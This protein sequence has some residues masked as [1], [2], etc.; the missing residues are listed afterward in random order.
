MATSKKTVKSS[1]VKQFRFARVFTLVG[2]ILCLSSLV[3]LA[4]TFYPVILEEL[5]YQYRTVA[6]TI[7]KP[8]DATPIDS[9]FGIVIPRL[10]A[11]ARIIA[12]VDPFDA[13][14]YQI[15]L[16]RGVA[17]ARGTSYPGNP[18]NIFLFSH[19]SVDFYRATQFNSVFYL[20]NKLDPGD[21]IL[22]YYK[23]EKYVYTVTGKKTVEATA[24]SYLKGSGVGKTLTL[25]T[26]WP[27]GTSFKRLVVLA[28]IPSE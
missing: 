16:T 7:T 1:T 8:I 5:G 11:N 18:G 28:E 14:A 21:E 13:K 17:H 3:I 15:A 4:L 12:N 23:N 6:K 22:L 24:V 19:S 10:G 9:D 25:M 2:F 26:C 20:L 27:P